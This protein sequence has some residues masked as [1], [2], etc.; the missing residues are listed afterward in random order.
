M[1]LKINF[2]KP[3]AELVAKLRKNQLL[4]LR[5]SKSGMNYTLL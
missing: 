1:S 4:T 2:V 3:A 5:Q